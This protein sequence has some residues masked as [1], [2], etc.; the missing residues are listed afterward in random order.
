MGEQNLLQPEEKDFQTFYKRSLFWI[1]WRPRLKR[2]GLGAL[3]VFDFLVVGKT[4]YSFLDYGVIDFFKERAMIGSIIDGL[5]HLHTISQTDA[6][7]SLKASDV[8]VFKLGTD[9]ADFYAALS[10]P[11]ADWQA[12]F[13]YA[14]SYGD[15][16]TTEYSGFILPGEQAK[17]LVALAEDVASVPKAATLVI[18]N[19]VWTRVNHHAI[20]DYPEWQADRLAFV[21]GDVSYNS[22]L[23]FGDTTIGQTQFTI[24]NNGGFGYWDPIFTVVL[25]RNDKVVGV[26][27][28]AI[29]KFAGGEEKTITVNWLSDAPQANATLIVPNIDIFD[30]TVYMPIEGE[31]QPDVRIRFQSDKLK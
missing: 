21:E 19:L 27:T 12:S 22:S 15:T 30:P 16:A 13:T 9:R 17:P 3:I 11:N 31:P 5:G 1:K 2:I 28:V 10:N 26:N 14:F 23:D 6:A 8:Q 25:Y 4:V 18:T 24:S 29:P 20:S 7:V